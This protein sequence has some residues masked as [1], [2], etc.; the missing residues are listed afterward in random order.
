MKPG[1]VSDHRTHP[2][3]SLSLQSGFCQSEMRNLGIFFI[4]KQRFYDMTSEYHQ[5]LH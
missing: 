4:S 3:V 2:H 5:N 1:K